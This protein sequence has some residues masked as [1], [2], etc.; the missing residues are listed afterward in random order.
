M[1]TELVP[2]LFG[3]IMTVGV[4][5]MLVS[6]ILGELDFDAD[7]DFD[8][9]ADLDLDLDTDADFSADSSEGVKVGCS[10]IAAFFAAFGAVGLAA[11]LGGQPIW[12][13]TIVA[14][15]FGLVIGRL[16]AQGMAFLKRQ[17][18]TTVQGTEALIGREAHA[19]IHIHPG[20]IGEG[21][22][23]ADEHLKYAIRE[24]TGQELFRGDMVQVIGMEGNVLLVKKQ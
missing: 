17:N 3:S 4:L 2:W 9:D 20:K 23:H 19:T 16:V 6:L 11:T 22:V 18:Y 24:T 15:V 10:A 5:Y 13:V 8:A 1:D 7:V 14:A 21:M 12:L